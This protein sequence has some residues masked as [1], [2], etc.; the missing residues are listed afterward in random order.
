MQVLGAGAGGEGDGPP[1]AV[2][3]VEE[4]GVAD[5]LDW[6]GVSMTGLKDGEGGGLQ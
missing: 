2:G 6:R 5:C 4:V 3:V 1:I